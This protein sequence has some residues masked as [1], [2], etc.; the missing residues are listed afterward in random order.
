MLQIISRVKV[1]Q[2]VSSVVKTTYS[3]PLDMSSNLRCVFFFFL[4]FFFFFLLLASFFF[5]LFS[6]SGVYAL[7]DPRISRDSQVSNISFTKNA[8]CQFTLN[9]IV[10]MA[11]LSGTSEN[12][13]RNNV[14]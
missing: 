6:L 3:N 4:F 13:T 12:G 7:H 9:S 5:L 1:A 14:H 2:T 10:I 8:C 11:T